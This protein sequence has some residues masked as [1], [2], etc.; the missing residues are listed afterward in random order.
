M[1]TEIWVSLFAAI[2]PTIVALA[3]LFASLRNA[4]KIQDVHISL[5]SRLSELIAASKTQG[6]Q[7]E[8]DA[9]ALIASNPV[10]Q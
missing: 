10:Q 8:R 6:R 9:Q 1:T 5:N 2:P 7:D 4:A 3:A